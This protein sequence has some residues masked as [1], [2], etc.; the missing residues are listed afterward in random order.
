ML[1][2]KLWSVTFYPGILINAALDS[3][4]DNLCPIKFTVDRQRFNDLQVKFA[5]LEVHPRMSCIMESVG[6]S[7]SQEKLQ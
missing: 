6:C 2:A 3:W 4:R 7:G 5:P 1:M